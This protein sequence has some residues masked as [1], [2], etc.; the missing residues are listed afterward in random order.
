MTLFAK[1]T[2][3]SPGYPASLVLR[4]A[5]QPDVVLNDGESKE[6][7]LHQDNSLTV[8]ERTADGREPACVAQFI[9]G[10]ALSTEPVAP[11]FKIEMGEDVGTPEG[12][13]AVVIGRAQHRATKPTYLVK[14]N[15]DG[16]ELTFDEDDLRP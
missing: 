16:A 3:A 13:S 5:N 9:Q 11:I 1:I 12:F 7:C 10:E 8:F 6:V 14:C 4:Q 15:F 2:H